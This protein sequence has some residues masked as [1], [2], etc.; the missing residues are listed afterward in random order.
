MVGRLIEHHGYGPAFLVAGVMHP[1]ALI[2]ILVTVK[3]VAP[4][5]PPGAG[6][7]AAP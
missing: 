7:V 3:R 5:R 1:L 2:L 6:S 4:V